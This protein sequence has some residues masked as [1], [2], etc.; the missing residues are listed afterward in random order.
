MRP[1]GQNGQYHVYVKGGALHGPFKILEKYRENTFKLELPGYMQMCSVVNMLRT[2]YYFNC[3]LD[4]RE[5][6]TILSIVQDMVPNE[7]F[8]EDLFL[9]RGQE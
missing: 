4:E 9:T 2:F 7:Q 8:M 3:L 6:T 1:V 5:D